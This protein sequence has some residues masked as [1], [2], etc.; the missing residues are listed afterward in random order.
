[1]LHRKYG[2]R[3]D[4][5]VWFTNKIMDIYCVSV[6]SARLRSSGFLL[7]RDAVAYDYK[8]PSLDG[9]PVHERIFFSQTKFRNLVKIG[10][11]DSL[12]GIISS[13]ERSFTAS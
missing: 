3:H 12:H 10:S 4:H 2:I 6:C 11:T 8:K 13:L 1:M 5:I 9:F 7:H